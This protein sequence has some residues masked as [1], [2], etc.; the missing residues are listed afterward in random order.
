[1][2]SLVIVMGGRRATADATGETTSGV[3]TI[4]D[5]DVAARFFWEG[6]QGN[7]ERVEVIT[8]PQGK[9]SEGSQRQVWSTRYRSHDMHDSL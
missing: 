9:E 7:V 8:R 5:R 2:A 3:A 1:L 4:K 6:L